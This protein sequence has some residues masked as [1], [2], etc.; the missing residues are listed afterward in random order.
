MMVIDTAARTLTGAELPLGI[1]T[2]I[3]GA[4]VFLVLLA[5]EHFRPS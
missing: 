1:L 5:R 2:G 4:P 3:V